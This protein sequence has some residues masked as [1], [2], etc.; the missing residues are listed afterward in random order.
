MY[1][2]GGKNII[3]GGML[4]NPGT[5]LDKNGQNRLFLVFWG[6]GGMVKKFSDLEFS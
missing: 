4:E 6:G 5:I 1:M 3:A 2:S